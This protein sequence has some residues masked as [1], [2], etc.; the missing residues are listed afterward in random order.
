M[1]HD[2]FISYASEN[3]P[4]A[5]A[6]VAKLEGAGIRCWVAPRDIL[7]GTDYG[8]SIVE[9]ITASRVFVLVFSAHA[10]GSPQVK[11]EVERAVAKGLPIIPFRIEEVQLSK[12]M[13]YYISSP[14]WLDAINPPMEQHLGILTDT[15]G[16]L[17]GTE[18]RAEVKPPSRPIARKLPIVPIVGV[19]LALVAVAVVAMLMMDG[20]DPPPSNGGPPEDRPPPDPSTAVAETEPNNKIAEAM[21]LEPGAWVKVTISPAGDHD[22]FKVTVLAAGYLMPTGEEEP[23]PDDVGYTF[24]N[25]DGK[26][27]GSGWS[28]RVEAGTYFVRVRGVYGSTEITDPFLFAVGWIP[29]MDPGEPNES[30]R[31]ATP[32]AFDERRTIA[33]LPPGDE[34][35]FAFDVAAPGY[36][37]AHLEEESD[38]TFECRSGT[39]SLGRGDCWRVEPGP[40]HLIVRGT[41]GSTGSTTVF[42]FWIAFL[43]EIDA[44]EPNDDARRAKP[45]PL[46]EPRTIA[47]LPAGDQDWF[48][49]KVTETGYLV[50]EADLY[51]VEDVGLSYELHRGAKSL[52]HATAWRVEPGDYVLRVHGEYGSTASAT[53]FPFTATLVSEMDPGEPNDEE[54]HA[55]P[56]AVGASAEAAL[57]PERDAD[58]F[59]IEV[60]SAG[61][62]RVELEDVP[63]GIDPQLRLRAPGGKDLGDDQPWAVEAGTY[64]LSMKNA[65]SS[66]SSTTPFRVR[67]T[68][69]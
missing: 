42:P 35:W 22:Y 29:E 53:P 40:H 59:R 18:V 4:I 45:L 41:S 46:G 10:N 3:K 38:T 61:S 20:D 19:A 25:A 28:C 57:M 47:I 6:A 31:R 66:G 52:G 24:F 68:L 33:I 8:G 7:P 43:A 36:V 17:L 44:D 48:L 60:P 51:E 13:E 27:I 37:F 5:D 30:E 16:R 58:W 21:P 55:T 14:H 39:R 26:E 69:E 15:V 65:Y 54:K 49:L 50:P 11:R 23:I 1:A 2:V 12:S 34:D 64:L 9:A 63:D 62:L 67:V 32:L 56:L